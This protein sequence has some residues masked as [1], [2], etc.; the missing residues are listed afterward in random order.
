MEQE[1]IQSMKFGKGVSVSKLRAVNKESA[2][3]RA[4][5]IVKDV[6]IIKETAAQL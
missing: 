5:E 2:D 6:D 1:E 4:S 3:D